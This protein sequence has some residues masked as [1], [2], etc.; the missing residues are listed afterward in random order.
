MT[1]QK[2]DDKNIF[3]LHIRAEDTLDSLCL[4][5]LEKYD[6][7]VIAAEMG[8][9]T[10]L[11]LKVAEASRGACAI[12]FAIVAVPWE[13]GDIT[14]CDSASGL[15]TLREKVF[16]LILVANERLSQAVECLSYFLRVATAETVN[17]DAGDLETLLHH[18]GPVHLGFGE[19]SGKEQYDEALSDAAH[20]ELTGTEIQ[21]AL[22]MVVGITISPTSD[23]A[24]VTSV[25]V[26]LQALANPS[27]N[28]IY[29]L[30]V[31]EVLTD[32]AMRM[33][34]I[35]CNYGPLVGQ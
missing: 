28:I 3:T 10:D 5:P 14:T 27:A 30:G 24:D 18:P 2:E 21:N 31:D 7:V 13:K 25:M 26:K 6:A 29:C 33:V 22:N 34:I 35:A 16:S 4:P 32:A 17:V 15:E 20:S 8:C 1:Y 12:N 19:A 9:K 23:M 11:V